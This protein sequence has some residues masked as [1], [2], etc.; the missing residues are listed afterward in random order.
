MAE[1]SYEIYVAAFRA[2]RAAVDHGDEE[3][4]RTLRRE[5]TG[6][7]GVA[8]LVSMLALIEAQ[9][10]MPERSK[11]DVCGGI[12]CALKCP[13]AVLAPKWK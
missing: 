3:E 7:Y 13:E 2:V 1:C 11:A 9:R 4:L 8:N 12:L 5:A 6:R 10:G